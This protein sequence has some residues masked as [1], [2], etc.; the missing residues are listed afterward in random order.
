[1]ADSR[2]KCSM[3]HSLTGDGC[4]Y[5]QPQ[6]YID[7]LEY[8][9]TEDR[10]EAQIRADLVDQLIGYAEHDIDCERS[11]PGKVV[12]NV[13]VDLNPCTCGLSDLIREVRGL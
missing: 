8:E 3:A 6:T 11:K 9:I 10:K 2:C 13:L 5:C 7:H 4:R 12:D 1:M